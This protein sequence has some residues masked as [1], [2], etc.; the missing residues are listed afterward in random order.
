MLLSQALCRLVNAWDKGVVA[1]ISENL[2]RDE[3]ALVLFQV[4]MKTLQKQNDN[5]SWGHIPSKEITAYAIIAL[6]NLSSLPTT[7]QLTVVIAEAIAKGRSFLNSDGVTPDIEYVWIAK[8]NYSPINISKAYV[9]AAL[10]TKF[11]K[12]SLGPSFRT[13]LNI[14]PKTM[15]RYTHMFSNLPTLVEYPLWRVEGSIT[16]ASLFLRKLKSAKLDMLDRENLK[17]D[18]YF[19]FIAMTFVC[20][21]NLH[22]SFLKSDIL[23]DMM[24][25]VLHVY[26]IDEY[27]EHIIGTNYETHLSEIKH[28]V[29]RLF[30]TAAPGKMCLAN[31]NG[32]S[33]KRKL[34]HD[35]ATG[36]GD[37][38]TANNLHPTYSEY[39]V[40]NNGVRNANGGP[41][42]APTASTSIGANL[43]QAA[44]FEISE[45]INSFIRTVVQHPAVQKADAVDRHLL[46][47]ELLLCLLAHITQL[48]DSKSHYQSLKS[49]SEWKVPCGSYHKWVRTIAAAHS[50]SPL[51]LA[52]FRCLIP[53]DVAGRTV[54]AEEQYLVQDMWVHLGNKAR[55]EN[56]RAS[57]RRDRK[58]RNLNSVD[59]P[60]FTRVDSGDVSKESMA[61]LTRIINYEKKCCKLGFESLGL[62]DP[63]GKNT[64][65][66]GLKFYYFLE[67][68]YN[69]V[70]V[71]KDISSE[72][73]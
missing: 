27:F 2:L 9:I 60:E 57:V 8:T 64:Q 46:E 36:H 6:G 21:N 25:F 38:A 14:S 3:V 33:K 69:D 12:Y 30:E 39:G 15:K 52:F 18:E 4:L 19:E 35:A 58:E 26:Q 50:C 10:E 5:G 11:P 61:Q 16:E 41:V 72:R 37:D 42:L 54:S 28:I 56:D 17:G 67:E 34:E 13:L 23:F 59:F 68:I 29:V 47:N 32:G 65:M 70:Y 40:S 49:G 63:N 20:A 45:K 71:L 22:G 44:E 24:A 66:E 62:L 1:N 55:M 43:L 7:A 31:N 48:E 51:S 73:K 53:K